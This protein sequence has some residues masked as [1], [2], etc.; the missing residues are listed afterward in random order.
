[1]IDDQK[2]QLRKIEHELYVTDIQ[3][4]RQR[5]VLHEDRLVVPDHWD[6]G[7]KITTSSSPM[8]PP[9][10]VSWFQRI[11]FASLAFLVIALGIFGA[12]FFFGGNTLSEDKVALNLTVKEF[13]DGGESLPV[14]IDITNNNKVGI[15][16]ATLTLSY[17]EGEEGTPALS[18][19][20][21]IP[22]LAAGATHHESFEVQLFGA[23]N[24]RKPL[25]A[26]LDFHLAGSNAVYQQQKDVAVLI[27]TTPV[28]L[29]ADIPEEIIPGQEFAMTFTMVGNGTSTLPRSAFVLDAPEGFTFLRAEPSPTTGTRVWLL[30]DL[31]PGTKRTVVVHGTLAG[32]AADLASLRAQ[33]GMQNEQDEKKL[34]ITYNSI[35]QKLTLANAFIS[36]KLVIAGQADL[37]LVPVGSTQDVEVRILWQNTLNVPLTNAEISVDLSGSAYDP[38]AV[39]PISG[40]FDSARNRIIWTRQQ[41]GDFATINPGQTG[42]ISFSLRPRQ[43]TNGSTETQQTIVISTNVQ[44]YQSGGTLLKASALETK[45]L[46]VG[47]D[48]NV[49]TKTSY[50]SGSI[51]NTGPL[52]LVSQKETTFTLEFKIINTRNQVTGATLTTTLPIYVAWKNV[53]LPEKEKSKVLFNEV[54][55]QLQWNIGDL[56]VGPGAG[57]PKTL[58]LKVGITPS[59]N[60]VGSV[61]YLTGDVI[62][63]GKDVFTQ[64]DLTISRQPLT[65]RLL[66]EGNSPGANGTVS[67]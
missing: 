26:H 39:S 38:A 47:T 41:I 34:D 15:E 58:S 57:N 5:S 1:M 8:Q 63:T 67:K 4:P 46:A 50:A 44:G 25:T 35:A 66:N 43:F 22:P 54:T 10:V 60:Q 9:S 29:T 36:T 24:S 28:T 33:V 13:V 12:T 55:R 42:E 23:E 31:P 56:P 11:F 32:G 21:E 40:F 49:L 20:R 30:G 2:S 59:L 14:E 7:E 6:D 64:K 48:L 53:I 52:P 45:K 61:P 51:Q 27:R 19:K 3:P 65:T 62:L 37:P 18:I 16:L 17:P